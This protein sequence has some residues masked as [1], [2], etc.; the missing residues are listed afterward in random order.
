MYRKDRQ[1]EFYTALAKKDGYPARSVYKLQEIDKKYK[2]IKENSQVLD[3]GCAPGS[4]ILY[5]SQKVGNRGKVIGVD[6]EEIKIPKK[7]NITFIKKSI[8]DLKE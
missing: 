1:N 5:I 8:F 7:S 6:I 2:I 3:L 4:W